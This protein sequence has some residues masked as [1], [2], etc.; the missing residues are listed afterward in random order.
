MTKLVASRYNQITPLTTGESALWNPLSGAFDIADAATV[1][2]FLASTPRSVEEQNTWLVRGYFFENKAQETL[3]FLERQ[4]DFLNATKENQ[5]QFMLV[6]SYAC[7]FGCPYCY[8]KGIADQGLMSKNML[9]GFLKFILEYREQHKKE[10]IVSLF[11]GEPLL[12]G[13]KYEELISYLV[14]R[15]NAEKIPLTVVTNGYN[16]GVYLPVLAKADLREVHVTLDGDRHHHDKRRTLKDGS[17][18]FDHIIEGL[19]A[20]VLAKIPVNVRIIVDKQNIQTLPFLAE[21]FNAH[22]WL[23]LPKELFKIAMGRNYELIEDY[24]QPEDLFTLDGL[25]KAYVQL[26]VQYPL[27]KKMYVPDFFGVTKMMNTGEM[28]T[29]SFDTCPG[30]KSE[31]VCDASGNIYSCTASCGRDGYEL[32][33]FYPQVVWYA[34]RLKEWQ[35]RNILTIKEC[36]TCSVAVVCGGGC[37][38]IAKDRTGKA[39]APNCKPVKEVMDIGIRY[40]EKDLLNMAGGS[41]G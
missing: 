4:Q 39:F 3:Y 13:K 8:Q 17:K 35:E 29:P 37:G 5:M 14:E 12:P 30:A 1:A 41:N 16:L 20:A 26:L 11:G 24:V 32:G 15:L 18:T 25:V 6:L 23:D 28:Y 2:A 10:I 27:L 7:N 33:A 22:G 9:D 21:L 36:Q 31:F 34:E 40:Y 38:V 19:T